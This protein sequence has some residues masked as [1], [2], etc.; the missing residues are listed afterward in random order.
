MLWL[1]KSKSEGVAEASLISK[2]II[3]FPVYVCDFFLFINQIK[4]VRYTFSI[5][6]SYET[7]IPLKLTYCQIATKF[8]L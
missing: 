1:L 3:S 4:V 2:Q 6:Y 7:Q 8:C 5:L